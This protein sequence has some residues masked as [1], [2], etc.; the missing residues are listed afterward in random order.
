MFCLVY[1]SLHG[2]DRLN[3]KHHFIYYIVPDTLWLFLAS[4]WSSFWASGE[5]PVLIP[6]K[7][8]HGNPKISPVCDGCFSVDVTLLLAS[9]YSLSQSQ[10]YWIDIFKLKKYPVCLLLFVF[11]IV[12]SYLVCSPSTPA[13]ALPSSALTWVSPPAPHPPHLFSLYISPV[14]SPVTGCVCLVLLF[15]YPVSVVDFE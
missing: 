3:S 8:S 11:C 10:N 5:H 6:F 4:P 9:P 13:S 14:F 12:C 7:I 15:S 1:F 2:A